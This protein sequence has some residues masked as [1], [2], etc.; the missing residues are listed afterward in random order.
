MS[1]VRIAKTRD[2]LRVEVSRQRSLRFA[3][4]GDARATRFVYL[5]NALGWAGFLA[6]VYRGPDDFSS[7]LGLGAIVVVG[8]VL[9][10]LG[11]ALD[12]LRKSAVR[13]RAHL[14]L[15]AD[16]LIALDASV[17]LTRVEI[18]RFRVSA[19]GDVISESGSGRTMTL[20]RG[21]P[22]A[23]RNSVM[24]ALNDWLTPP[25]AR[26]T[27]VPPLPS[28]SKRDIV[29]GDS[30]RA[31]QRGVELTFPAF[32]HRQVRQR[33]RLARGGLVWARRVLLAGAALAFAS[34]G[35]FLAMEVPFTGAL[36]MACGLLPAWM[37]FALE[38]E[39][40]RVERSTETMDVGERSLI[41]HS[42]KVRSG[43]TELPAARIARV[44]VDPRASAEGLSAL[45]AVDSAGS[46]TTLLEALRDDEAEV[47]VRELR[48]ALE[49]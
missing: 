15:S 13:D 4:T 33:R 7:A 26:N 8:G 12:E 6:F 2:G 25:D 35:T 18:D 14:H 43:H 46:E 3:T 22:A 40:M 29:A 19:R 17:R 30:Y 9:V 37:F 36:L 41:V 28:P 23:H 11:L 24:K 44:R 38:R 34:A 31:A 20:L 10:E 1:E 39:G 45:V 21:V 32:T 49:L 48:S 42:G 27:P 16:T 47:A 5:I